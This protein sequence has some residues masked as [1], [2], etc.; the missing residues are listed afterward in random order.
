MERERVL[1]PCYFNETLTR[2]EGRRVKKSDAVKNPLTRNIL[3]AVKKMGLTAT[4]ETKSHPA[5]WLSKEGR[6]LVKWE[7]S[8]ELLIQ[9]VAEKLKQ[10]NKK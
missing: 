10:D 9:N 8:K 5:H 3:T 1:Y 7:K 2:S 6:V 4:A